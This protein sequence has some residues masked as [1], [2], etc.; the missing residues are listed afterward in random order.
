MNM[1]MKHHVKLSQ[2]ERGMSVR[3]ACLYG[4]ALTELKKYP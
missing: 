1:P 4:Q 3:R 2:R